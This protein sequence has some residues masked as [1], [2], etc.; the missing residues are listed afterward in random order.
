VKSFEPILATSASTARPRSLALARTKR[1]WSRAAELT[2]QSF[3]EGKEER[4]PPQ[5]RGT[6]RGLK[7]SHE[8]TAQWLA[9]FVRGRFG[10]LKRLE[11]FHA[12]S[13]TAD[14]QSRWGL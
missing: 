8:E 13:P 9:G 12:A 11:S 2:L 1:A 7:R 14:G 6:D 4:K 10:N 3:E 5:G